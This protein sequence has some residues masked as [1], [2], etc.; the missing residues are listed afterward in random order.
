[1]QI[2]E[3]TVNLLIIG[4]PGIIC[5]FITQKLCGRKNHSALEFVF[6]IFLYS[7]LSY[8]FVGIFDSVISFMANN[9][10]KTDVYEIITGKS[11]DANIDI[12]IRGVVFGIFLSY[13]VSYLNKYNVANII[14]DKIGATK[15]YG[16]EDVWYNFHS[17]SNTFKNKGWILVRDLKEDLTYY[18][19]IS[20]YS[21]SNRDR[22]LLL[23]EVDVSA[24]ES[25][26][27]LYSMDQIYLSRNRDD[28]NIEVPNIE[29]PQ[30]E[31]TEGEE[32]L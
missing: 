27:Y 22:E 17:L 29:E 12:I 9:A 20:A 19:F 15:R 7:I 16:S 8:S 30:L 32:T 31:E 1:M 4:T 2:T 25:G 23:S 24:T 11:K 14:G 10:F 3:Y 5:Y 28:I 21:D 6:L 13:V 26:E 18:G